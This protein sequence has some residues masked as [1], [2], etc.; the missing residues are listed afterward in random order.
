M[1]ERPDSRT[2]PMTPQLALRVTLVGTCAL[3]MFAVIFFRLWFLQVLSGSQYLAQ[4]SV[5]AQRTISIPSERGE[6]LDSGGQPLVESVPVPTVEIAA[7]D[8]PKPITIA[9][10]AGNRDHPPAADAAL[11]RKLAALLS[12]SNRTERCQIDG[13]KPPPNGTEGTFRLPAIACLVAQGVANVAYDNVTI[14]QNVSTDIQYY[15]GERQTEFPGVVV[16]QKYIRKY[17]FGD[18]AAQV[19]GTVGPISCDN[20][21]VVADCETSQKH[22]KGIADTDD[23]GQSGLEYQYNQF[24]QGTDGKEKVKV[25]ALGEFEGYYPPQAPTTGENLQ[26]S[27]NAQLQKIGENALATSIAE[28]DGTGGAFVAMNPDNGQVYAMGSNPTYD[29]SLFTHP[30]TQSQYDSYFGSGSGDPLLNRAIQSTGPTGST[31]KVITATAALQSG[32]WSLDETYD[33]TGCFLE[34]TTCLSNSG[35]AAYGVVNLV[36]AIKVSDDIFFYNLGKLLNSNSIKGG[37]LQ[38][39][40]HL[41]GIGR[42]TG[43]DLPDAATG[44]MSSPKYWDY[45][46]Q[47]ETECENATGPYKHDPKH[48]ASEGGCGIGTGT[49]WT[50]GDNV[51]AAVGQGDDQV[52]PLQLAVAYAALANGGTIVTP[53]LG[54]DIQSANGTVVQRIDPGPRRKLPLNPIYRDAILTGLREAASEPGGTSA[55]V[56]GSFPSEYP[57]YGKTGTA[58][59]FEDGVEHDYAWYACFVP[60]SATSK[61]IVVVVWVENGGFGDVAS[62]PV[63]R[64]ILSQWF[65][66]KPGVF[67]AGSSPD[68]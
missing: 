5:N 43:I 21:K 24:L 55:D 26:V 66:G 58:Q 22:F 28:N 12:I 39:W 38:K 49:P 30:L 23:V 61:P 54:E 51:N 41:Y 25:N 52:S 33:D 8:L 62:A 20:S 50:Y 56:M 7:Q 35:H 31:F 17:P 16:V 36:D 37:P 42:S 1:I 48:P 14:A 46:N 3:I 15:L 4:A 10:M 47:Q 60:A 59:Y 29:P 6:I 11:Y 18:L 45:L 53:H 65:F 32:L 68:M 63:A 13:A 27:I 57:V 67:K 9:E 44:A 64:Q 40:A 19:L 2:P 34:G